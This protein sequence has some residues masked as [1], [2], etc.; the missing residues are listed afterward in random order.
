MLK[1][2]EER[3]TFAEIPEEISLCIN[4]S[5]CPCHCEGCHSAYLAD[6]IGEE[7]NIESISKLIES[8][9][10]ISCVAFMGGDAEPD[11]I[12]NLAMFIRKKYPNLKIAWYSGRSELHKCIEL[13]LNNFDY[14]KLGPYIPKLGPLDNPNTNQRLYKVDKDLVDITYKFWRHE[15][16]NQN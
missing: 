7:L 4:I 9:T 5:N 2:V 11:E 3:V 6:D 1:Y 8:N 15:I 12:N 14:I 16:N 13:S 10:G